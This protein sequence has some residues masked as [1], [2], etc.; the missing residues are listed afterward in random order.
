MVVK[1]GVSLPD[2]VYQELVETAQAMGYTSLS[3]AVRD[4]VETFIAFNKW[5]KYSG[6]VTGSIQI[7]ALDTRETHSNLADNLR[8]HAHTIIAQLTIPLDRY[9]LTIIVVRGAGEEIKELYKKLVKTKG[10]L[11]VQAN[12]LPTH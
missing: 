10:V 2:D 12:L 3:H 5:W 7:L 9:A 4:A 6:T 8:E 11:A 1:T